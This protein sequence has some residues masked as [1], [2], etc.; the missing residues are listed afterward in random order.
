MQLNF[1]SSSSNKGWHEVWFNIW[2][3]SLLK[4]ARV[5]PTNP[6]DTT[7]CICQEESDQATMLLEEIENLKSEGVI[8]VSLIQIYIHQW[9]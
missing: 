6:M 2:D 8:G 1:P 3:E 4:Y 5:L 7:V 9:V